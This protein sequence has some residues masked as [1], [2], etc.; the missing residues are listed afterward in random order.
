MPI[1]S[2]IKCVI[3]L[4]TS[5]D[6][7]SVIQ[8]T[9]DDLNIQLIGSQYYI[10]FTESNYRI[11]DVSNISIKSDLRLG[12]DYA[13]YDD[14]NIS[15]VNTDN[16]YNRIIE[17]CNLANPTISSI[18]GFP[19]YIATGIDYQDIKF[20]GVVQEVSYNVN[21]CNII[22]SHISNTLNK[23]IGQTTIN[24]DNEIVD[25]PVTYGV[26]KDYYD[27][28]GN[29][30]ELDKAKAPRIVKTEITYENKQLFDE[31]AP[32]E[33]ITILPEN[34]SSFPVQF[35]PTYYDETVI[36]LGIADGT[37]PAHSTSLINV[38]NLFLKVS[39]GNKA[40][41]EVRKIKTIS[42]DSY[43]TDGNMVYWPLVKCYCVLYESF[44]EKLNGSNDNTDR[45]R[46]YCQ[47]VKIEAS[48]LLDSNN[49]KGTIV[50]PIT[51]L[52]T[53]GV[54]T[55]QDT[56]IDGVN[57]CNPYSYNDSAFV[58]NVPANSQ[59]K[60]YVKKDE[61]R[62][63]E[64]GSTDFINTSNRIDVNG[65]N[66][67]DD[68]NS[69]NKF[70]VK[71]LVNFQ[72]L[73]QP[74]LNDWQGYDVT[75]WTNGELDL[76]GYPV[77]RHPDREVKNQVQQETG[78]PNNVTD[79][80]NTT[81]YETYYKLE[82]KGTGTSNNSLIMAA[83]DFDFPK[84]PET[85]DACYLLVNMNIFAGSVTETFDY[86][87]KLD[88]YLQ[89]KKW[90]SKPLML[91]PQ[92]TMNNNIYYDVT[93]NDCPRFYAQGG[94]DSKFYTTLN[95]DQTASF[96]EWTK[97]GY[98]LF[99][100]P[101][102][103]TIEKYNDMQK[104]SLVIKV[105]LER[106]K[107]ASIHTTINELGIIFK[108]TSNIEDEIYTSC[109]GRT[110]ASPEIQTIPNFNGTIAKESYIQPIIG[111]YKDI[112]YNQNWQYLDGITSGTNIHSNLLPLL[113]ERGDSVSGDDLF[114]SSTDQITGSRQLLKVSDTNSDKLKQSICNEFVL[115]G[116]Y[117]YNNNIT[118]EY[119]VDL[120]KLINDK[121]VRIAVNYEDLLSKDI[122]INE[123][124]NEDVIVNP[125]FKYRRNM[126]DQEIWDKQID[127]KKVN[128]SKLDFSNVTLSADGID[129]AYAE[130][131]YDNASLTT[132]NAKF[133]NVKNLPIVNEQFE[134]LQWC[135]D[136][137]DAKTVV[138]RKLFWMGS[139]RVTFSI[140]SVDYTIDIFDKITLNFLN[141]YNITGGRT[142]IVESIN[143]DIISNKIVITAL[144]WL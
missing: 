124:T 8:A 45:D 28:S 48:Y 119:L 74:N 109:V 117:K 114:Y 111:V 60:S 105:E 143:T 87:T 129:A 34:I 131:V 81:Q 39:S 90:S 36:I 141:E 100:I 54:N 37:T 61:K 76:P 23:E 52:N 82:G 130:Y 64:I 121:E 58:S 103:D 110:S 78:T 83:W 98:K 16:W 26:F 65:L 116:Y 91:I 85:F 25:V 46:S 17:M 89:Y 11:I 32:G 3:T 80:N 27:T 138:F 56:Y 102:I 15:V 7:S 43:Q 93:L 20:I 84:P 33:P 24:S 4:P 108:T 120:V 40:V 55:Y 71:P 6:L 62:F 10:V 51:S 101:D 122:T 118:N 140:P 2:R 18:N 9:L 77:Y 97:E 1:Q 29:L 94:D 127:F 139:N 142:G 19:M 66:I 136:F 12:G 104:G 13:K 112:V 44:S 63:R 5:V 128:V 132:F 70:I 14:T 38:D 75:N 22:F 125:T 35:Q 107:S 137:E 115:G 50:N 86:D 42:F 72:P 106:S 57:N 79:K 31:Y 68:L 69:I 88:I 96:R 135:R 47:I 73:I 113:I 49:C 123:P 30:L 53:L 95:D 144:F 126:G 59:S 21:E 92:I 134:N 67:Q 99:L 133:R 41:G